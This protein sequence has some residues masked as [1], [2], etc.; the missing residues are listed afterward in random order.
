MKTNLAF[1]HAKLTAA[2]KAGHGPALLAQLSERY[3]ILATDGAMQ[4]ILPPGMPLAAAYDA[5]TITSAQAQSPLVTSG[6]AGIPAFLTYN[7]DPKLIEVLLAPM[8]AEVI[9]G[10]AEK[11]GDWTT[12]LAMF[13]V[14]EHTGETAAY[15]DFNAN[16]IAD[17]NV[18]YP[19]RQNFYY[20]T[21]TQWGE[22]ELAIAGLGKVDLAAQKNRASI[23]A[24]KKYQNQIYFYGVAGLQTYGLLNDPSLPAPITAQYAWLT[25]S[26]A[27]AA[28]IYSDLQRLVGQVIEQANGTVDQM[29]EFVVA[30]SPEQAVAL[31][32]TNQYNVNVYDQLK[33]NFP[34]LRV[35]TAPEY[36]TTGGQ[37]VQCIAVE[38]EGV[39]TAFPAFSELLRAHSVVADTSSWKQKKSQG[40]FGTVIVRPF[41]ISQ[42]IA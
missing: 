8:K 36:A 28:T 1:D 15:G 27:T 6:N 32:S 16:G 4:S 14:V 34:N 39:R 3:G 18:N 22:R 12:S 7:L 19:Q 38:V 35:E 40:S 13:I 9:L 30:M 41:L 2:I 23:I 37:L 31:N 24:L 26:S 11:K 17:A 10:P 42:M 21:H 29:D 25:S 20:Q 33:K 5:L